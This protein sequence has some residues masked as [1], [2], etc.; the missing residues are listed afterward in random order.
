MSIKAIFRKKLAL[1]AVASVCAIGAVSV[2]APVARAHSTGTYYWS[3]ALA[4]SRVRG[5]NIVWRNGSYD[6]IVAAQCAGKGPY[7]WNDTGT[8][9]LFRHFLCGV[10]D[11][12]GTSYYVALHVI[13]RFHFNVDFLQYA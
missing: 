7:I 3:E 4:K 12:N 2:A 6:D 13:D 1:L 11:V 8:L 9:H 10:V 5:E